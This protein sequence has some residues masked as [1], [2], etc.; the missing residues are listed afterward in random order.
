MYGSLCAAQL[1]I[2]PVPIAPA[3]SGIPPADPNNVGDGGPATAAKLSGVSSIAL[4][5]ARNIFIV[6]VNSAA[7]R[8][9][10]VYL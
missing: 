8:P 1:R 10:R 5:A 4:D 9:S 2:A 6:D 7:A 3:T